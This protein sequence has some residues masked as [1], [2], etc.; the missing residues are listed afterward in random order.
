MTAPENNSYGVVVVSYSSGGVLQSFLDSLV[1]SDITPEAVVV[2]ENGPQQPDITMP[3]GIAVT[4]LH[5][6]DN[7]GYGTAVNAG[8]EL[9]PPG[10]S[11]VLVSN[12]DVTLAPP[13]TTQLLAARDFSPKV[14]SLAPALLNPDGTVYPSARAV[15]SLGVGIG[16]ALLA[17][18]WP[19]NPW[20]TRYRG[21]YG[22]PEPREAGW[23]SGA[24]LMVNR[25]AF[26]ELTGFDTQY[27]MFME[28]VDL[29]MRLGQS[30][31]SNVY[32]PA[33]TAIHRVGHATRGARGAMTKA[34]HQSA[35]RFLAKR[36]PGALWWPLRLVTTVG[37]TLRQ[38][39]VQ[40]IKR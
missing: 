40:A 25:V 14:G 32:V 34:H 12:P 13:T 24:C 30:G 16:H 26:T 9:L 5:K 23:L 27:F 39:L 29:G 11:W 28:D 21:A 31:W 17:A 6:P 36:Y 33:A 15:P 38:W 35:K 2:V 3:Q 1:A 7:P 10:I 20:T 19:T 37:L 4:I 8:M 22:A 18:L